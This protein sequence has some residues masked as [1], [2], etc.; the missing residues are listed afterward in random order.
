[1]LPLLAIAAAVIVTAYLWKEG[2]VG[3]MLRPSVL[4]VQLERDL[5]EGEP[6]AATDF[7]LR[8]IS[9][10]KI[11]PG[12]VAFAVGSEAA[13]VASVL[14]KQ[15]IAVPAVP[16]GRILSSGML[17]RPSEF[18]VIVARD[19]IAPGTPLTPDNVLP[20]RMEGVPEPGALIFGTVEAAMSYLAHSGPLQAGSVVA[21]GKVLAAAD[22]ASRRETLFV[23]VANRDIDRMEQ[24]STRVLH[25]AEL[26][27]GEIPSGSVVFP[28][29]SD[30]EDF[31]ISLDRYAAA[32]RV[33]GGT[34]ITADVIAAREEAVSRDDSLPRTR[35][36]LEAYMIAH[37]GRAIYLPAGVFLGGKREPGDLID[38]WVET[39]R[40]DGAFGEIRLQRLAAGLRLRSVVQ[41]G[42]AL[43]RARDIAEGRADV[44]G[45]M[46]APEVFFWIEADPDT[47]ALFR[48][49]APRG[50]IAFASKAWDDLVDR[51]GNGT[52]CI[53]D[54]CTVNREASKDLSALA[55]E[56]TAQIAHDPLGILKNVTPEVE[57]NLIGSGYLDFASIAAWRDEDLAGLSAQLGITRDLARYIREQARIIDKSAALAGENLGMSEPPSQ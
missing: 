43:A 46:P 17:T 14:G 28:T 27:S 22:I 35:I 31:L 57:Q 45:E 48:N 36:E 8:K 49:A 5:H 9:I 13:E 32:R 37:P 53:D 26:P 4:G 44:S 20:R 7:I 10:E 21:R 42:E 3:K 34:V 56:L 29:L 24:L 52:S 15:V 30:A 50:R 38:L 25:P 11:E 19:E 33:A 2:T 39:D 23:V 1:M 47:I 6:I 54:L 40:T 51:L 12:M 18:A 55:A 16:A 41:D